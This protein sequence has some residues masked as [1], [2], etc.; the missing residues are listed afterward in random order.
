MTLLQ[1]MRLDARNK[2]L[3]LLT[4]EDAKALKGKTIQTI[5]FG[6]Q[7]QDGADEFVVGDI[8]SE[9]DLAKKDTSIS[10]HANRAA[11]W[12]SFM[13]S[14]RLESTKNKLVLLREDGTSTYIKAE[15]PYDNTFWC[16]DSDRFVKYQIKENA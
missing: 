7:G 6:Y 1:Q 16:S 10:T 9:Y 13:D 4:I 15:L 2:K 3:Q 12:E 11:Y 14:N 5:Y 8:V